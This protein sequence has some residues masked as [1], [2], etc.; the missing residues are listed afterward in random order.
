MGVK[1]SAVGS[2]ILHEAVILTHAEIIFIANFDWCQYTSLN[3]MVRPGIFKMLKSSYHRS[4][5]LKVKVLPLKHK[6]ITLR[7]SKNKKF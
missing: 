3:V 1:L 7:R 5:K 4:I 6:I 2:L